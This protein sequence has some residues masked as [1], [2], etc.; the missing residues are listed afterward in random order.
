MSTN[1]HELIDSSYESLSNPLS[2]D[3]DLPVMIGE[4][5]DPSA[6]QDTLA[7]DPLTAHEYELEE[8][9][10]LNTT[11]CPEVVQ[12]TSDIQASNGPAP[13]QF[14]N[15]ADLLAPRPSDCALPPGAPRAANDLMEHEPPGWDTQAA[16]WAAIDPS[17]P[18]APSPPRVSASPA[19]N[20]ARAASASIVDYFGVRS[21]Q[22]ASARPRVGD[23]GA[24]LPPSRR[25]PPVTP[26]I[27]ALTA[28]YLPS[29]D[30]Q[31]VPARNDAIVVR[32]DDSNRNPPRERAGRTGP[33]A[34]GES[35]ERDISP[36]LKNTRP[37]NPQTGREADEEAN[38]GIVTHLSSI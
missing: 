21:E 31:R 14:G 25:S 4:L 27:A 38:P 30:A 20:T 11:A 36:Q 23:A 28:A 15:N 35:E 1:R 10:R 18:P 17:H 5:R 8:Y 13:A 2:A 9:M 34:T 22:R 3:P 32:P 29:D 19:T 12:D 7:S 16:G 33:G 24:Q 6:L 26:D 37:R